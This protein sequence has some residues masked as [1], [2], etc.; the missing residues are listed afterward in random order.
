[1]ENKIQARLKWVTLYERVEDAGFVC[2]RCG[3]SRPTLRKWVRRYQQFGLDGLADHSRR[4]KKSPK[5]KIVDEKIGWILQLRT[6]KNIGARRIQNE[7]KRQYQFSL[8]LS[9][10]QKVLTDNQ[11]K[12]LRKPARKKRIHGYSK[13][14]PGER[15]QIDTCMIAPGL[16][17]YT[18]IDDCTRYQVLE[19]YSRRTAQNTLD[20][21]EKVLEEMPFPV[22]RIQT[23]RGR[24]FFAYKVQEWLM[25]H[26]I[27]F[28]PI[29]PR[30]PHLNG[31]VER[32]QRTDLEEFYVNMNLQDPKLRDYLSEWQHF[33]NWD[34]IHGS[35]GMPPIDRYFALQD[36][37]PFW[38][39]V[40]EK[41]DR[42]KEIFREQHYLFDQRLVELK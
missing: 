5:K 20:F 14:T 39:D 4:P 3:I 8:S 34:R 12:P 41:Y 31:K 32:A 30:S 21:L 37:T 1:M 15:V 16:Y 10:I 22:Q 28:R 17:Q 33:Y 13:K 40:I 19:I 27:K 7:L 36:D 42:S 6:E 26:C 9:T 23:D 24:E 29:R 2:R 25:D 11:V 35:I 38:E 18:A